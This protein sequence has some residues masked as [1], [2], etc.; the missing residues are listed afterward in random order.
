MAAAVA[1]GGTW[2]GAPVTTDRAGPVIIVATDPSDR[3]QWANKGRDHKVA[4]DGWE[5]IAFTPERWEY[6]ADLADGLNSPLLVF[7][8][9]TSGLEGPINEADPSSILGPLGRIV[10]AGTPVVVIAHSGKSNSPGPMGPTAYKAWRRHGIH[11]TGKGDRRI[12]KRAGNLGSWPDVVVSGVP[13]GAAVEYALLEGQASRNR[14]PE[15]L[16]RNAEIARWVVTNCQGKGVN[17]VGKL[18]AA[19][20]GGKEGSRQTSLKTGA[21]SKLLNREG[22]GGSTDWSLTK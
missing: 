19:E 12:L 11:V 17:E 18:V 7:D 5:L 10:S 2:L 13:N 21:L 4:E 6:Y 9:I 14:S 22:E 1:S 20:F 3:G 15:R 16:D 8:N